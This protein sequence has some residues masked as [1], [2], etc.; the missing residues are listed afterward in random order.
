VRKGVCPTCIPSPHYIDFCYRRFYHLHYTCLSS[1]FSVSIP[2]SL[3]EAFSNPEWRQSM[4][5]EMYSVQSSG[6]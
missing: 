2:K 3:G 1:L 6:T 5:D 4:I